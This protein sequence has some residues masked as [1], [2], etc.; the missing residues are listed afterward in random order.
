MIWLILGLIL[1]TGAH[2][3]KRFAPERRAAMGNAGRGVV[4][5]AILAS[6]VLMVVGYRAAAVTPLWDFGKGAISVN[7]LLM[8]MAVPLM[9]LGSSKSRL[10]GKLRHPMLTGFLLWVVAHLLVNGDLASLIMFG[11]LGLW[12]IGSIILINRAEPM[13]AP[14]TQGSAKGD[15]RL[16]VIGLVLFAIISAIHTWL[17]YWPFPG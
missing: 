14:F 12:A 15:I 11:G 13:P 2:Y 17:G 1:W 16:A 3:F 7:N 4:T 5:V 9:G 8:I 10:R 6:V